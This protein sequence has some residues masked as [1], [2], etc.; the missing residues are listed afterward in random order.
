MRQESET[1]FFAVLHLS[2]LVAPFL[3]GKARATIINVSSGLGFCPIAFMTVYCATNAF[4]HSATMSM[5]HSLRPK[6][7]EVVEII[8]PEVDT[9]LGKERRTDPKQS[10]GGTP[11]P[12][13][14]AGVFQGLEAGKAETP[15]CGFFFSQDMGWETVTPATIVGFHNLG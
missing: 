8:P 13:F 2:D 11:L 4:V 15:Y 6:G 7:I 12:D 14:I 9:E 10:H 1:N 5:R 3:A